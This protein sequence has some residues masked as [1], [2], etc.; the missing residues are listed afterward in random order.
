MFPCRRNR[1]HR[2][3]PWCSKALDCDCLETLASSPHQTRP[4]RITDALFLKS[5]EIKIAQ[6]EDFKDRRQFRAK[7]LFGYY[8]WSVFVGFTRVS[9]Y[10]QSERAGNGKLPQ[11]PQVG[12]HVEFADHMIAAPIQEE[13]IG[14]A[15]FL[16]I[17]HIGNRKAYLYPRLCRPLASLLYRP[18]A[19]VNGC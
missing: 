15:H 4:C 18:R 7:F 16:Q 10:H 2:T 17:K 14:I 8:R 5:V 13:G 12:L 19:N 3:A 1:T 6:L 9:G 11:C